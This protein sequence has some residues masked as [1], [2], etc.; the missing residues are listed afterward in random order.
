MNDDIATVRADL[1]RRAP[2]GETAVYRFFDAGKRLLYVGASADP[3]KRWGFHEANAEW[4]ADAIRVEV[5]W[6]TTRAEALRV[7]RRTIC[8]E[9]PVHNSPGVRRTLPDRPN[10]TP[11]RVFRIDDELWGIFDQAVTRSTYPNKTEA[12]RNFIRWFARVPGVPM[13]SRP[14]A[15]RRAA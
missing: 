6:F 14:D 10:V 9:T 7:E 13:P 8:D 5:A 12:L 2:T 4:W 1:S 15:E 11:A 3:A